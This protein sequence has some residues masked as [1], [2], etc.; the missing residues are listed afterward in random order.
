LPF[1]DLPGLYQL[2]RCSAYLSNYEGFGIPVL[3]AMR[4]NVPVICSNSS[5]IKEVGANAALLVDPKSILDIKAG[6]LKIVYDETFR[7]SLLETTSV[8]LKNFEP[9]E[10]SRQMHQLYIGL[11]K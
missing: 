8:H 5:S 10:L 9:V 4:S 1:E 11:L 2:A 7:T 6:L 3:E